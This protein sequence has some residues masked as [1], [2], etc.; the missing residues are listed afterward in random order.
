MLKEKG[1]DEFLAEKIRIGREQARA[2]QGV[3]LEVAKQRTKEKL[4]RKIRE[5]ELSRN[6]DVVYG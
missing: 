2:G 1:Y 5:M 4:E 3:P 6:R